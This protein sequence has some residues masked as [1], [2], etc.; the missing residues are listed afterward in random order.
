LED[1]QLNF[2]TTNPQADINTTET[3]SLYRS[4]RAGAESGWDFSSRWIRGHDHL[5]NIDT[6][7]IIPIDLNA[8]MFR[9]ELNL[10]Q[11]ATMIDSSANTP[12]DSQFYS[13]KQ[14]FY[15]RKANR[16][17]AAIQ[18]FMWDESTYQWRDYNLSSSTF[19]IIDKI[20]RIEYSTIANFIPMWA[21]LADRDTSLS[22]L[23]VTDKANTKR[24]VRVDR[25]I[26]SLQKSGLIQRAGILTTTEYTKQQWDAPNSWPPLVL[27]T[28]EGLQRLN[29]EDSNRLAVRKRRCNVVY[30]F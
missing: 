12:I 16:R 13:M 23:L 29:T 8:I 14:S 25:L 5:R 20:D 26:E 7:E 30:Y 19:S 9:F 24:F 2:N 15:L 1:Y 27:F 21:G 11:L 4:I 22:S 10:V 6:S 18:E 17:S 28:I 3:S